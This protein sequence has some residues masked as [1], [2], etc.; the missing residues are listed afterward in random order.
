MAGRFNRRTMATIAHIAVDQ[1]RAG[2]RPKAAPSATLR[3]IFSGVTPC[4]SRSRIGLTTRRLKY[5]SS[6]SG[7]VQ[8]RILLRK[9]H[10][11]RMVVNDLPSIW[12]ALPHQC[13]HSADIIFVP[14]QVPPPQNERCVRPQ[15][16][17]LQLRKI[18]LSHRA[19]VG[20]VLL[21]SRQHAIPATR[22]PTASRKRQFRR[23]P[24]SHQEHVHIAAVP[25]GL[26]RAKDG[27][28]GLPVSLALIGGFGERRSLREEEET[29]C[30]CHCQPYA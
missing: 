30:P 7:P 14:F 20:I 15:K 17:K 13:E 11:A 28:D 26:L 25:R 27:A 24:I 23:M 22:H 19:P 21:V 1:P 10:R 6:M 18:Q 8:L 9:S 5:P 4:R 3:A 12:K 29:R 2:N 16:A